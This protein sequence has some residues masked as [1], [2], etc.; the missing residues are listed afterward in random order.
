MRLQ[1][2]RHLWTGREG[3]RERGACEGIYCELKCKYSVMMLSMSDIPVFAPNAGVLAAP[4]AAAELR[5]AEK[6]KKM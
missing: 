1:T 5:P 3:E 2:A 6:M 4:K